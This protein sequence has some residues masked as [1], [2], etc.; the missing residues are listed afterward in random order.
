MTLSL[1]TTVTLTCDT[2]EQESGPTIVHSTDVPNYRVSP[3]VIQ[4]LQEAFTNERLN[5]DE[6]GVRC[7]D[8]PS[9]VMEAFQKQ[10]FQLIGETEV[11]DRNL[12]VLTK[13]N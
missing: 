9:V 6:Q 13:T 11:N 12:W 3:Y 1:Y 7:Q 2:S 10:G 8:P 4:L 5:D